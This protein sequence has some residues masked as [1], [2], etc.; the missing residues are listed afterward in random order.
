MSTLVESS[1][2]QRLEAARMAAE[3]GLTRSAEAKQAILNARARVLARP[4]AAEE[5][6]GDD[7]LHL[8]F[9][10]VGDEQLAMPLTSVVAIARPSRIAPL[11]RAVQPVYGVTAWRGRPLT[12]LSLSGA[13]PAI[14]GDTRLLVLGTGTRVALAVVVDVVHDVGRTSASGLAPAGMG[15]RHRY[16]L[17]I[18]PDG[19]LVVSGDALLHPETLSP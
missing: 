9:F 4:V 14:T 15:P 12:V 7:V 5:Q 1:L 17:G 2:Q 13:R 11:P 18:T 8:V 10:Q 6:G 3:K 19:L 16:T